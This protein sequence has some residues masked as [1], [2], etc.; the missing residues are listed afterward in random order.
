MCIRVGTFPILQVRRVI[1][2]SCY[3]R[4]IWGVGPKLYSGN[5][6]HLRERLTSQRFSI[7]V[8]LSHSKLRPITCLVVRLSIGGV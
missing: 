8:T 4:K 5:G 6:G 3:P 1:H 2:G 7:Q